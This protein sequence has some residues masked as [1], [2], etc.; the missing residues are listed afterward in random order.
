V[1]QRHFGISAEEALF[2]RPAWELDNLIARYV[3][4]AREEEVS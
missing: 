3:R 2:E 4:D 1:L